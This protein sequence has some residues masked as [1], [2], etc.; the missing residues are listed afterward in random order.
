[1]DAV[2]LLLEPTMHNRKQ[3]MLCYMVKGL[4]HERVVTGGDGDQVVSSW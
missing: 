2:G 4:L 1:V 3:D